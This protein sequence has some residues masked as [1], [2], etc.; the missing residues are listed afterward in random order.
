MQQLMHLHHG[1]FIRLPLR[2]A[3]ITAALIYSIQFSA[4]IMSAKTILWFAI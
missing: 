4:T 1:I 3:I 2:P